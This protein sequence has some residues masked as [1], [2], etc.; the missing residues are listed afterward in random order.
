[1]H[2]IV[3]N[4]R[5]RHREKKHKNVMAVV[6]AHHELLALIS[7]CLEAAGA[8]TEAANV[9]A[10]VLVDADLRGVSSHGVNRLGVTAVVQ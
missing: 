8:S 2:S 4:Q 5:I 9:T 7:A 6:V 3:Y 10:E 1:M